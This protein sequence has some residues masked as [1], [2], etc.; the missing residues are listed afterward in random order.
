MGGGSVSSNEVDAAAEP[1]APLLRQPQFRWYI[2][3]QASWYAS[4]GVRHVLFPWLVVVVLHESPDRVGLAQMAVLLPNIFLLLI[5]GAIADR[6]DLRRLLIVTQLAGLIPPLALA[7]LIAA[8]YLSY[9]L[10]V[11]YGLSLGLTIAFVNP[12]RDSLLSRLAGNEV[13]R[14]VTIST[15]LQFGTQIIGVL[16]AGYAMITGAPLLLLAQAGFIACALFATWRLAPVPSRRDKHATSSP[17]HEILDGVRIT[18]SLPLIAPI[19]VLMI[20]M[21][22]SFMG[23]YLV[24]LPVTIRDVFHGNA[25]EIATANMCFMTGTV[26]A[27]LALLRIGHVKRAGRCFVA[28]L[29]A[30]AVV[31][32]AT[33][34]RMPIELYFFC[35]FLSGIASG[36]M[37]AMSRALIQEASPESHRARILSLFQLGYLGAAPLGAM[38]Q[39]YL[40]HFFG[41]HEAV[42]AP[43]IVLAAII[44]WRAPGSGLWSRVSY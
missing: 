40:A 37:F 44:L 34:L 23:W 22:F 16:V 13:Q 31:I 10:I 24:I 21:G 30:V 28:S 11:A 42:L 15:G 32:L 38:A 25:P 3:G 35:V 39:G 36:L 7:A 41:A 9:P 19:V 4:W 18:R 43:A 27:T 6:S 1:A 2:A 20:A 5:G 17:W 29:G 33:Y 26:A 14:A 12:A 8:G